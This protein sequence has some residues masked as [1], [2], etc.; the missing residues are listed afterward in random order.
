MGE[1]RSSVV[2]LQPPEGCRH[3][4]HFR[5]R[6]GCHNRSYFQPL[7]DRHSLPFREKS[8]SSGGFQQPPGTR[9]LVAR[10]GSTDFVVASM[11]RAK[12]VEL[13]A[14]EIRLRTAHYQ[15]SSRRSAA[16]GKVSG[17]PAYQVASGQIRAGPRSPRRWAA[18]P[19]EP[20][21]EA[22]WRGVALASLSST[23]WRLKSSSRRRVCYPPT[24]RP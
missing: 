15:L 11:A 20:K 1:Y 6:E 2:R 4:S 12:P 22:D 19:Y 14:N 5:P 24:A 3:R 23:L 7:G 16:V 17:G 9:T 8:W 13:I 21:T 18:P 10:Y